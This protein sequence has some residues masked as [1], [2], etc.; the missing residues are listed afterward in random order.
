MS[1]ANRTYF[2]V[3]NTNLKPA[4][5]DEAFGIG[6]VLQY[7]IGIMVTP[8]YKGSKCFVFE[9]FE[10]AKRFAAGRNEYRIFTCEVLGRPT[11]PKVVPKSIWDI[12]KY[13]DTITKAKK[14]KKKVKFDIK[15]IKPV[16]GTVFVDGVRLL[17]D[18]TNT[19]D[20][21]PEVKTYYKCIVRQLGTK[22]LMSSCYGSDYTIEYKIGKFVTPILNGSKLFI[23]DS[24]KAAK[25]FIFI[26]CTYC[27]TDIYACEA[28]G[29]EDAKY[30][31]WLSRDAD[32][33]WKNQNCKKAP[34]PD[35]TKF[36]TAVKLIEKV[37]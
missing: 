25:D 15:V 9:T 21:K 31:A 12:P 4:C 11:K 16:E 1:K 2:K 36:A 23:F 7:L 27:Y 14:S 6:P 5:Q 13:W 17:H 3:V 26:N 19:K 30:M 20:G 8:I 28:V 37:A 10:Q 33:F 24:L 34:V 29:V 32:K 22:A 35:G 18:V